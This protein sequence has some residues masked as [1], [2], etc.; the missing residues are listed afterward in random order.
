MYWSDITFPPINLWSAPRMNERDKRANRLKLNPRPKQTNSWRHF[1]TAKPATDI[2]I[3]QS[4][5]MAL[6]INLRNRNMK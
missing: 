5:R 1:E 4:E 6:C 2:D 3:V